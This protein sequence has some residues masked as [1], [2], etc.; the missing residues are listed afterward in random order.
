M[1]ERDREIAAAGAALRLGR[2]A[3][4]VSH[5]PAVIELLATKGAYCRSLRDPIDTTTP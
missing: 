5:L 1:E 3:R 2:L 4:S